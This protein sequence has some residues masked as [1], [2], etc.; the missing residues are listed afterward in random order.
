MNGPGKLATTATA[1]VKPAVAA[2]LL[3]HL[4]DEVFNTLTAHEQLAITELGTYAEEALENPDVVTPQVPD[5]NTVPDETPVKRAAR[6]RSEADGYLR[7]TLGFAR[8]N[9]LS[10]LASG[11]ISSPASPP[12]PQHF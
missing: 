2:V 6:I 9:Q 10:A 5:G 4:P 1:P 8:F 3:T 11:L 7:A 12:S